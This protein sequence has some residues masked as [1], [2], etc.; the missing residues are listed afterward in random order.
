MG[1]DFDDYDN[2]GSPDLLI[3]A[4]SLQ[5]YALFRNGK[6]GFEDVSERTGLSRLTMPYSGWGMKFVDYDN[7]G[8]KD[9]FVAQGH[10]LDTI[11]VDFPRIPHRQR[12]MLLRNERGSFADVSGLS[13][14]V[15]EMAR[16]ARGA[17]FGDFN[18]D[19]LVD[20]AL[21]NNDGPA[22]LLRN[23]GRGNN[24]IQIETVGTA[25]NRDGIGALVRVV[26]ESGGGAAPHRVD[27]VQLPVCE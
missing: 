10:V 24:W 7:D 26:G 11:S 18:R 13:G 4:L 3:N 27:G 12:L 16:A 25:S 2:D 21:N 19:G 6:D 23:G 8:W 20:V 9:I 1:I 14:P 15:F 5:G 22:A 17:A